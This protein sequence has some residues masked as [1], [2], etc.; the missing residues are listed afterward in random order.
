MIATATSIRPQI[1]YHEAAHAIAL[2]VL[3]GSV[4]EAT[5]IPDADI[6]GHMEPFNWHGAAP[7][8]ITAMRLCG[9]LAELRYLGISG[10]DFAHAHCD[11]DLRRVDEQLAKTYGRQVQRRACPEYHTALSKARS[12]L[13]GYWGAI[14]H[15]ADWLQTHSTASG[16]LVRAILENFEARR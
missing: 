5:A 15:V 3:G 10:D 2:E 4:W 14:A 16:C 9:P 12:I 7:L 1:A 13:D 11:T 8:D 6:L